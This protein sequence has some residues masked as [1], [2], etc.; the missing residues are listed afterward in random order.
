MAFAWSPWARKDV[1]ILKRSGI[2]HS[3]GAPSKSQLLRQRLT[4]RRK[5]S[6]LIRMSDARKKRTLGL[7]AV[8]A[9]ACGVLLGVGLGLMIRTLPRVEALE[10]YRPDVV[11]QILVTTT[12]QTIGE[13]YTERRIALSR[14]EIPDTVIHAILAAEDADFYSHSGFDFPGILRA[15]IKNAIQLK[16]SQ[17]A[18]PLTQQMARML[19]LSNEKTYSRKLKEA[20]LTVEIERRYS[21]DEIL[22]LYLNQSYFGHGAYGIESAART[23]FNKSVALLTKEEA[24]T[25]V[26]LLKNPA[27]FSPFAP[28]RS[29]AEEP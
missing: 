15:V 25:L 8:A 26:C 2:D 17:G 24:S 29:H 23:F 12:K 16:K 6:Y 20:L 19:F 11:T 22:T 13:F 21:K 1:F 14:S 3:P 5:I 4:N 28:S 27:S 18:S 9:L 10:Y 7:I